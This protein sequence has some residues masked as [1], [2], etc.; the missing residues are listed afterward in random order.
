MNNNPPKTLM[1]Y[2]AHWGRHIDG[3]MTIALNIAKGFSL[4]KIPSNFVSNGHPVFR[5]F[6][7]IGVDGPIEFLTHMRN[8]KRLFCRA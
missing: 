5:K 2:E 8:I 6:E 1:F 4:V 7:E 3:S